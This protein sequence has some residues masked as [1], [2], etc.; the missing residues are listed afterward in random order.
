LAE[1]AR[2]EPGYVSRVVAYLGESG[3]LVHKPR[4]TVEKVDWRKILRR[5]SLDSPFESRGE[6]AT[7]LAGHGLPDL[8]A[9]LGASGFLHAITGEL[10][11]ADLA[12]E[13][14]PDRLVAYVD[15][16]AAAVNQFGLH[17]T[18]TAGNVM[19]VRPSDRS[20]FHRS[21]ERD[22]LRYV[23]PSVMAADLGH[24]PSF[25]RVLAWMA[26]HESA[27]RT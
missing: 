9:R 25:E 18:E 11:F 5:W 14:R 13:P 21:R 23:S 7:F 15:D 4:K 26:K 24:T 6:L 1:E 8:L 3:M 22:R 16:P 19:L 2:V 17:S 12:A 20:V 27:W 10:A